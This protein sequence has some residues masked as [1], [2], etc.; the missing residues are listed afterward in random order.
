MPGVLPRSDVVG[1]FSLE[2][3]GVDVGFLKSIDGGA[4]HA[5]VINESLGPT[6]FVKK[7][8]GP[9]KY[10][11]FTIQIGLGMGSSVYD[12]LAASLKMN[13]TR[14]NGAIVSHDLKLQT[15]GER[16]FFNAVIT[17]V[18]FPAMDAAA[19]DPCYL[20][21][22]FA[23][24]YTRRKPGGIATPPP[25]KAQETWLPSNFRLEIDGLDCTRVSRIDAFTVKQKVVGDSIGDARDQFKEPARIEFPNL[26]ITMPE[27]A[28][29]TWVDWFESFVVNGKNDESQEKSGAL[30]FLSPN[31]QTE[32]GRVRFYNLGIFRIASTKADA[33]T[34][35][36]Q[37]ITAELYCE[38]MELQTT[39]AL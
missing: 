3:D 33:G 32:L 13:Y 2:L 35:Q 38:R 29:P 34:D 18:G 37:R 28:V 10:E 1:H 31:R 25:V 24:E 39:K 15:T 8:I 12:W 6:D 26:A 19:K 20:T 9:P 5:E 11:P 7:H 23:P 17:E 21:V 27:T 16:E 4:I 36:I 30:V 22:K 14:K